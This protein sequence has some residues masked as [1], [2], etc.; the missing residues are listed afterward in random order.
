[1]KKERANGERRELMARTEIYRKDGV[2]VAAVVLDTAESDN[3]PIS[4]VKLS[5]QEA[6]QRL[7]NELRKFMAIERGA[8]IRPGGPV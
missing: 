3:L 1:M 4:D 6:A 2:I 5:F 8:P 7:E